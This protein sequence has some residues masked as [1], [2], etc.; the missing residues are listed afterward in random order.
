MLVPTDVL[1][2]TTFPIDFGVLISPQG[3]VKLDLVVD[4]VSNVLY[5]DSYWRMYVKQKEYDGNKYLSVFVDR[6]HD[7]SPVSVNIETSVLSYDVNKQ[8]YSHK[9]SNT[10]SAQ[11]HAYGWNKFMS[12]T[13]LKS[14]NNAFVKNNQVTL[15]SV[16]TY[17][18]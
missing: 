7:A 10:F 5:C 9:T 11:S 2:R 12:W 4:N 18:K 3:T 16:I 14:S 17:A 6:D 13:K 15:E 8:R 1:S